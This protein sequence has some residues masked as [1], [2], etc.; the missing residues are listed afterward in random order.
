MERN[1]KAF[2]SYRH[3]PLDIETAKKV[4]RRIERYVIPGDLRKDGEKKLGLVFRDQ[5]ELPIS[6]N[7]TANIQQA[8]DHAEY[9][10]VICSPETPN[11]VWVRREISYFLE[12]HDRDHVLAV[13]VDGV[14]E[15]SFPPELTE[16]R[17]EDGDLLSRIEPLAANIAAPTAAK[18]ASLFKTES[19]RILAALIGCPFDA[20]YRRELRYRRRRAAAAAGAGAL[21]AAAFIGMLLNRNAQI[22]ARLLESQ[23]NESRALAALAESAYREGDYSGALSLALQALPE[24]GDRP[25]V[26]EAEY[27]LSRQLDLYR[28]GVL[29]YSQSLE[30]DTMI[31]RLALSRDGLRLATAD[32]YGT[33]RF[34]NTRT[35]ELLWEKQVGAITA[36]EILEEYAA[37]LVRGEMGAALYDAFEGEELWRRGDIDSLNF[38]AVSP[39]HRFGLASSYAEPWAP[40]DT[41]SVLELESGETLQ[42]VTV[43]EGAGRISPAAAFS[44]DAGLAAFLL[45]TNGEGSAT[46]YVYDL[47]SGELREIAE[48]LPY[49]A[50]AVSY[51]LRFTPEGDLLLACD[52]RDGS[53][54]LSL[55]ARADDWALRFCTPIRTEQVAEVVNSGVSLF[56]SIDLLECRAGLAAVGSK[57]YLYMIDLGTGEI[58]WD[59]DLPAYLIGGTM[60]ENASMFLALS[61]GTVTFCT[62]DGYLSYTQNIYCFRGGYETDLAAVEGGSFIDSCFVLVPDDYQQRAVILRFL[63]NERM[64]PLTPLPE[65][66]ARASMIVSPS[67]T[68]A[69]CLGYDPVGK[70]VGLVLLD[71]HSGDVL[72]QCALADA[73]SW[74]DPGRVFLTDGGKLIGG[75]KVL[76]PRTAERYELAEE[77]AVCVSAASTHEGCV[78]T[79]AVTRGGI[80]R[81]W[82]DGE[83]LLDAPCPEGEDEPYTCAAVGGNG[84]ALLRAGESC[85]A[86]SAEGEWTRLDGIPAGPLALADEKPWLAAL[87]VEGGAALWDLT[88]GALVSASQPLP[89]ATGELL[90]A[91]EDRALVA[92]SATG[93]LS[94]LDT[95]GGEILCTADFGNLNL[96]FYSE[97]ARYEGRR[98]AGANRLILCYDNLAYTESVCLVL[99]MDSWERVGAFE[100]VSAYLPESDSVL[101]CPYLDGVYESPLWSLGDMIQKAQTV[102]GEEES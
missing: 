36:V 10:I 78:Y 15:T 68:L 23:I 44:E 73:E 88:S 47:A 45:L 32:G 43:S 18:R 49:S 5:D 75:G 4:H 66:A 74:A 11:S 83:R 72:A 69:A 65:G 42:S 26:A 61:N 39:D 80:L 77:G 87:D 54:A 57:H 86:C 90:F 1:Y 48:E 84:Y 12:H 9:L 93:T 82:R 19:L 3:R 51:A 25:Y 92:F 31:T 41:V 22:R 76:D 37:I 56:T 53:S 97:F 71:A 16:I 64:R 21:V 24:D 94:V 81:F 13:L 52:N 8:L 35:G 89:A 33:L 102:T 70:P 14:P 40:P 98:Q 62:D 99:D 67:G 91:C 50:G 46:L 55:Y 6:S 2:I 30:Q 79:A 96:H 20:L 63:D 34:F 29:S 95:P 7:L 27:T 85:L 17:G 60:Y 58:L 100:G 38:I 28:Q 59:K 101:V